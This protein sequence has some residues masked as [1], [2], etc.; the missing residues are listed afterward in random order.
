MNLT[1]QE[2]QIK[3][4]E[5][6]GWTNVEF[7]TWTQ[8]RPAGLFGNPPVRPMFDPCRRFLVPDY[9]NDLNAMHEAE[10]SAGFHQRAENSKYWHNLHFITTQEDTWPHY[11]TAAQRFDAFG[12]TLNL[13]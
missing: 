5:A 6:C 12:K 3:V 7:E 10:K 8:G 11:A 13:W 9:A 4:A 2:K 1:D